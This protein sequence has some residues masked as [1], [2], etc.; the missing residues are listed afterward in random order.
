MVDE[1]RRAVAYWQWADNRSKT[2]NERTKL[3]QDKLLGREAGLERY[4][5][6]SA[7]QNGAGPL[8]YPRTQKR[9]TCSCTAC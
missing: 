9:M 3:N 1:M 6:A 7:E 2:A 5:W 4:A 8:R